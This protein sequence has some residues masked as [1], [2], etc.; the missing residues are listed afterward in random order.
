M[1]TGDVCQ[2]DGLDQLGLSMRAKTPM[3]GEAAKD[4]ENL[5]GKLTWGSKQGEDMG[6][7]W[8]FEPF[9]RPLVPP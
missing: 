4:L 5:A 6:F 2:S 9:F 7:T 3:A 1:P 8:L